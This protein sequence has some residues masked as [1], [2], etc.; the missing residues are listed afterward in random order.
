[1]AGPGPRWAGSGKM[2]VAVNPAPMAWER[3]AVLLPLGSHHPVPLFSPCGVK[4]RG[5]GLWPGRKGDGCIP[6]RGH[7]LAAGMAGPH[8]PSA[9]SPGELTSGT[10]EGCFPRGCSPDPSPAPG[11]LPPRRTSVHFTAWQRGQG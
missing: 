11:S 1:M 10:E 3:V 8:G 2:P 5:H 9:P 6:L 7:P 4:G